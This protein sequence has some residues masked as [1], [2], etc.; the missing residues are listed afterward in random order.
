M[1]MSASEHQYKGAGAAE[2]ALKAE[3]TSL[4]FV[5]GNLRRAVEEA[6]WLGDDERLAS[7]ELELEMVEGKIAKGQ[8]YEP[9]W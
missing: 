5:R 4:S 9:N 6:E 2:Q 7:L 3:L 1:S 8:L